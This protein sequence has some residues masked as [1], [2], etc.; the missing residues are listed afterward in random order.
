M[1]SILTGVLLLAA[2]VAS[3]A[4]FYV[5]PG[6][7]DSNPGSAEKPFATLRQ[8]RDAIRE[9]KARGLPP[10]RITVNVADGTYTLAEPL[11]LEPVDSGTVESPI[12]YQAAPGAHPLLSGGRVLKGWQ[13]A[14]G[15]LWKLHIP[16]VAAGHW[17]F[18]QLFVNGQ[19]A[20]RARTP[21]K[22]YYY[23]QDM[24]ETPIGPQ[25]KGPGGHA[26]QTVRMRQEDAREA[27]ARIRP[28]EIADVN[29]VV[30]HNWDNTR[31]FL[32]SVD[33]AEGTFAM[34]GGATKPWNPWKRNSHYILENFL[35]A[36]DSPGEWFL[37]R[38]GTLY[39]MPLPGENMATADVVAPVAE[40]LLIL[41]GDPASGKFVQH[42]TIRGL[43]F[44]HG[45]WLTPRGGFQPSQAAATVEAVVMA[46]G[47]RHVAIEDCEIGHVGTYAVWFRRGCRDC[48]LRHS[49]IHD[50]GAGGV[51]IGEMGIARNEAE[52]TGHVEIDNNILRGGGRIF[53][54]AVGLWIGQSGDNSVTHNE[55]ADLFYTGIS[56][57]W[58]WGYHE[59]LAKRNTFAFNHVHHLGYGLLSDMGGIYT[60][61]PSEGTVVRNNVFHDIYSYSYGGWGMYTDEGSTGILFENNLVYA[62]KT[63][64]FHQ[65]YGKENVLRNNILAFSLQHQLQATRVEDHLSF[66]LEGNIVYWDTGRLLAGPWDKLQFAARNNLYWQAAGRAVEFLGRPLAAWQALGH[67]QSSLAADP[68]FVDPAHGNFRLAPDSPALKMGFKPFDPAEAGVYGD[69]AWVAKARDAV[70]PALGIPPGPPA[71]ELHEDFENDAVG[72]PPSGAVSHVENHGDAI[73][74]TDETAAGGKHCVKIVD[75]PGLHNVWDP[76][77]TYEN[78]GHETGPMHNAFDLRI[79]ADSRINFEWRDYSESAYWTGPRFSIDDGQLVFGKGEKMSLPAGEWIHFEITGDL[80]A[81]AKNGWTLRVTLP[82]GQPREFRGLPL[83]SPQ[84]KKLTWIGFSSNAT[85][86]TTFYLDNVVLVRRRP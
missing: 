5:A 17:Y 9:L 80:G 25:P 69:A 2:A 29:F 75:A 38:N 56:A 86:K 72:H 83:T 18:E 66:T 20:T 24:H 74:V 13:P 23:V 36:L 8:A 46:D 37:A 79:A 45:Q 50:F 81:A 71:L 22:F 49:Y 3:A 30:Y 77:L 44:Q 39:Y 63:G 28:E 6:G 12:V 21:N 4:E 64:S 60:L 59:N 52:R 82:G 41:A 43:R 19:R 84:F 34:S 54:C 65:H 78:L 31:Q 51:R 67:E 35:G 40:K 57:G 61:G 33:V 53:P 10:G 48:A 14:D 26:K 32:E 47:A 55:I 16:E 68:K 58:T 42:I 76:H 11:V 85:Y 7:S 62:T 73:L 1:K 15:G 27:L 70:Y